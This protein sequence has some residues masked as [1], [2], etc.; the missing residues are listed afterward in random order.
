MA[1]CLFI[2]S[3]STE[4][5][6]NSDMLAPIVIFSYNRPEHLRRTLDALS[7][8][9]YAADSD[10]FVFCDG[11]KDDATEEQRQAIARNIEVAKTINGFRSLSVIERQSNFGLADNIINAVTEIVN[12]YG[13]VI[14]LED[15][16]ITS[17]GFLHYMNSALTLYE[18]EDKV[19]H[20]SGYMYPHKKRLP[21]T[22]FYEVPYPGGGWATWK[23]AW[24]HFSNDIDELYAYW[25]PRWKE[26]NRFGGDYLQKQLEKNKQGTMYT[27]FIKWHAVLLRMGGL[28]LY[29]QT[30]L[31]NNIG[32]D[33]S[34]SNCGTMTQFDIEHPAEHIS[35][36]LIPIKENK[37]AARIIYH[38]YSGHWYGK[39]YRIALIN[40][41]K[42]IFGN[43]NAG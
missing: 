13:K 43:Q 22:F 25:C 15:D 34:G 36:E 27:W 37:K 32:F 6:S 38:F 4:S 1:Q 31:T 3:V 33:S 18:N 11:A 5:S 29:P 8:N 20:I 39:R 40:R 7:K 42:S 10:L 2:E 24:D 16:V 19:M 21:E 28:T 17:I 9:L 41:I 14:T 30:S 23:R 26:F 12:R 35:V